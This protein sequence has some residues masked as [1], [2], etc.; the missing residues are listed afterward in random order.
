MTTETIDR[1]FLELSQVTTAKTARELAL[2]TENAQ[3]RATVEAV[4]LNDGKG[5]V[6]H[7][8]VLRVMTCKDGK[9]PAF[10]PSHVPELLRYI[11][12]DETT[13]VEGQPWFVIAFGPDSIFPVK[14]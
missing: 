2:E 9:P 14:K 3:L 13:N 10:D 4:R 12:E 11:G 1:L 7:P 8:I 6:Y 5:N